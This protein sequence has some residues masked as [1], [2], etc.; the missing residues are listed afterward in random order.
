MRGSEVSHPMLPAP[1]EFS[2]SQ[3]CPA[4]HLF[5]ALIPPKHRRHLAF[6]LSILPPGC[7]RLVGDREFLQKE[8][9]LKSEGLLR[10]E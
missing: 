4:V 2:L 10:P 9:A 5:K 1:P 6:L 8:I 7:E 3:K